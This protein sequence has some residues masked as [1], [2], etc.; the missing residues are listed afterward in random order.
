MDAQ[1]IVVI[2]V[3]AA[4]ALHVFSRI[5]KQVSQASDSR[6]GGGSCS[7]GCGCENTRATLI[8]QPIPVRNDRAARR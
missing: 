4:A 6:R 5:Y 7:A 2:V 8:K 3:V 1:M